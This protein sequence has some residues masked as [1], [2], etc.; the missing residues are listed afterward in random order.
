MA[1]MLE[2]MM[3]KNAGD[4]PPVAGATAKRAK[5]WLD[6]AGQ[7]EELMLSV[8]VR[9]NRDTKADSTRLWCNFMLANALRHGRCEAPGCS[10]KGLSACAK[11]GTRYCSAGCQ[12]LHWKAGH[13][14]QQSWQAVWRLS[15][16]GTCSHR[17]LQRYFSRLRR[18]E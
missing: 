17:N 4:E 7:A 15:L 16:Q 5:A 13:K 8:H 1:E 10:K 3:Q 18:L 2:E 11:C 6:T 14:A 12:K 9:P